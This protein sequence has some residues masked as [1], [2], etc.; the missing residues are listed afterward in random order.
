MLYIFCYILLL[1]LLL[2]QL[3]NLPGCPIPTATFGQTVPPCPPWPWPP[4]QGGRLGSCGSAGN[5]DP[6]AK[7]AT[8]QTGHAAPGPGP[9]GATVGRQCARLAARGRC[10]SAVT[11]AAP[12]GEALRTPGSEKGEGL[13]LSPLP[14]APETPPPTRQAAAG[15]PAP[16]ILWPGAA[17]LSLR[18]G[19]LL[20]EALPAPFLAAGP[21]LLPI[22]LSTSDC[23]RRPALSPGGA[24]G[25]S[26]PGIRGLGPGG[27]PALRRHLGC[28]AQGRQA[29][30]GTPS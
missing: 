25:R 14:L 1:L 5:S 13:A 7:P 22:S 16:A 29:E 19:H 15:P 21:G 30:L 12:R 8:L 18:S 24:G 26:P 23:P 20:R 17:G 4:L 3:H 27:P 6:K 11:G 9:R 2:T 28:G 10:G